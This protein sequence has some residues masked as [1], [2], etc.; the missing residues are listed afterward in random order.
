MGYCA[1]HT[2]QARISSFPTTLW[3]PRFDHQRHPSH[4]LRNTFG[5]ASGIKGWRTRSTAARR[6]PLRNNIS[7][8][9]GLEP[10][11]GA[12]SQV[13]KQFSHRHSRVARP[14]NPI[15]NSHGRRAGSFSIRSLYTYT[16]SNS[17]AWANRL[18]TE[19]GRRITVVLD[20]ALGPF[21]RGVQLYLF[22]TL[23]ERSWSAAPRRVFQHANGDEHSR[24]RNHITH[25]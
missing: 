2:L 14:A 4:L 22:H 9:Y 12:L 21:Y 19:A 11:S 20:S 3:L 16:M 7:G 13:I 15:P 24:G 5:N 17:S 8:F 1:P 10:P 25:M 18:A 6:Y 23:C